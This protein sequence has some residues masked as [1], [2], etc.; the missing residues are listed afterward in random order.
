VVS[1]IETDVK[2]PVSSYPYRDYGLVAL[3]AG[4]AVLVYTFFRLRRGT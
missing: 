4:A 2:V 3:T 1:Q